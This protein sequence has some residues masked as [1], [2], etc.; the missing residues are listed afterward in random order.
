ME[1]QKKVK[2][3]IR[4]Q[5]EEDISTKSTSIKRLSTDSDKNNSFDVKNIFKE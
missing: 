1:D 3:F 2:S 5:C 4:L